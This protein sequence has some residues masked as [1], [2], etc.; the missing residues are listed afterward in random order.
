MAIMAQWRGMRWE[1]SPNMIKAIAGLS[2]SYKLKASTD[3]DGRRKVE[4]FELQPLSLDYDVSDA[5]G[6][7]PRAEF[8]AWEGLVG[9]IGPFY[10]GGR[11]F[12]PRSVQLDEVSIG[13][14]VLDN[15]GRIRSAKISLKFT[16]Y[17]NEGGK[18][19]GRTQI[20]YNGVDIYNDISVNQ[21]FHD[22]FAASQSDELLLRFNDTRHLWDGWNP[23]NEETIE[24][25]EGAARSGKMF[26]ESVI[27][28]NGLMTL[29]AFSIP[30]TAKDPFTKS[31]EN[32]KLLQIGQE[33]ASRHG[34]GFEQYDVTDQLYD[35]VRQDNLPDFEFLEQRCA[36]EG[37][38]FLVFDGTLVMYGEAALEA[39][40]PAGSIDVPPDGVFEYHDD[41]T[42]AYGKAE[43]VNGDI[44]GSFA[45][46]SGGSKLLHRV[47]QIRI[48][49]QAEGNRFA[50]GLLRYENRNMTTGTLQTA[51][52]PEYAAGSVATL[53]TGG[54]GSWDGPAFIMRIRHDY[55]AKK[56]KIFFRKPLEG[57]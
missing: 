6:G 16:E 12:G 41:A 9:Q 18:G 24:V 17:A 48:A 50:K 36:L 44:T 20:L 22:M 4:G 53:K 52:L 56:S 15:F 3:E 40:A 43:V 19:Q 25:V 37:V 23:A 57:Y 14:L 2:T 10:L 42:A 55:V 30:P 33:I 38:A 46:P 26:I 39:K 8:E 29:R 11:R 5:A 32:V 31:W 35:Y 27:H 54:A 7:S 45:A 1:I 28:E 47:L 21:C 49:S 51:L 13:D 34:L